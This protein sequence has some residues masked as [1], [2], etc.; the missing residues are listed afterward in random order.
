MKHGYK[1]NGGGG[2]APKSGDHYT[3]LCRKSGFTKTLT[4]L[5]S[6]TRSPAHGTSVNNLWKKTVSHE[7]GG[8]V[9][10]WYPE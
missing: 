8:N 4:A 9:R 6:G 7:Q 2:T 3:P 5:A 1:N 10:G